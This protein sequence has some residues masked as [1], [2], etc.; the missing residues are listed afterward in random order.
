MSRSVREKTGDLY[1]LGD[2]ALGDAGCPWTGVVGETGRSGGTMGVAGEV[3]EKLSKLKA[4]A[5][6]SMPSANST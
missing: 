6:C 3:K 1:T 4:A 2:L 5:A